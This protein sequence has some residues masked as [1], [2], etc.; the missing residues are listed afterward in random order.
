[1]TDTMSN[2]QNKDK[3]VSASPQLASAQTSS[4]RLR[5]DAPGEGEPCGRWRLVDLVDI[6]TLQKL[7]D[8]FST[9]CGAAVSIR[10]ADG[11][12]IT[13]P[14]QPNRF[15]AVVSEHPEIEKRCR[16]SNS[17]S[18]CRAARKG[19]PAKYVCHAGLT[20]YAATIELEGRVLGTIVLGD[21]PEKPFERRQIDAL[22]AEM[23]VDADQ[24]WAM[25]QE[26]QPW[27]DSQMRAA[28]NFLQLTANTITGICYQ[29]VVLGQRLEELHVIEE[30]TKLLTSGLDLDTVLNNIVK[31]M[32]E[33]MKVKACS[34]RLLDPTGKE[35]IIKAAY[36]LSRDYL[37]KGP[38][39]V[40]E[41]HWDKA[42]LAGEVIR[43]RNMGT[44][45]NV[46]YPEEARREGL[47]SSLGVG[48]VSGGKAVGTLHI[49]TG[50]E[51]DF[52]EEEER[53]FLAVA[54]QA[55]GV[56]ERSRLLQESVAKMQME[57][58]LQLA[59]EVQSRMLP[60]RPPQ[61]PGLDVHAINIPSKQV[62]GDFYDYIVMPQGRTGI[63]IADTVG[64]SIPAAILTASV[65]SALKSQAQN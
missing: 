52:T 33:I 23:G 2:D 47:V 39:L 55:A 14:S 65:R 41:S 54:A 31:T 49:Y 36:N 25:A 4:M 42:I 27:S 7:Q 37:R 60:S 63:T 51:H 5:G 34:V 19:R 28:I 13:R 32:A 29:Q 50:Q 62:S 16:L 61:I 3:D 45:P 24:L 1:M 15:C 56:I 53:L 64:K 9:L 48:M 21:R 26:I 44:D 6:E 59:R 30:T 10:D 17:E 58:E 46:R 38:V 57:H 40:E 8:G 22:A 11:M 43:I 12:R 18:T 20:Q 35:L